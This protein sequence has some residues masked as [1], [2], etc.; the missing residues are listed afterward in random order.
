M[1]NRIVAILSQEPGLTQKQIAQR[2]GVPTTA[3]ATY[4]HVLA[5]R[6]NVKQTGLR[7]TGKPYIYV[8]AREVDVNIFPAW[9]RCC[10]PK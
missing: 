1:R 9:C 7:R 2:L 3:V 10:K 6:G 8:A 5:S 4:M